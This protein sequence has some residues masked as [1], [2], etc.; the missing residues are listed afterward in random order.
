MYIKYLKYLNFTFIYILIQHTTRTGSFTRG[1]IKDS[2]LITT[3]IVVTKLVGRFSNLWLAN[4]NDLTQP[5]RKHLVGY[6]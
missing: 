2:S 3:I 6:P 1:E 5:L 4:T